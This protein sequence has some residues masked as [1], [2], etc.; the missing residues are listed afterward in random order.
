MANVVTATEF[1]ARGDRPEW[2]YALGRIEASYRCGTFEGA[3]A[4]ASEVAAA[5]A[6][7]GHHPELDVRQPDWLHVALTT[8]DVD[9]ITDLDVDL[10][11]E[12]STLAATRGAVSEPRALQ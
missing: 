6:R 9:A 5:A 4:L 10:S 12:I 2:R 7:A 1:H 8:R 11:G 3:A